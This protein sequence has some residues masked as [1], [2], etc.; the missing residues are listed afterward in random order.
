[1]TTVIISILTLTLFSLISLLAYRKTYVKLIRKSN[2]PY[3]FINE[4]TTN[5]N[6]SAILF[7][8]N[9][10]MLSPNFGSDIGVNIKSDWENSPYIYYLKRSE[11]SPY[12]IYKMRV[13]GKYKDLKNLIITYKAQGLK[14]NLMIIPNFIGNEL[15]KITS[16]GLEKGIGID[17]EKEYVVD[18]ETNY[19]INAESHL[20]FNLSPFGKVVLLLFT[21]E[22]RIAKKS[23][24]Y[25]LIYGCDNDLI[26]KIE[27]NETVCIVNRPS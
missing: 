4:N 1:M 24:L 14:G 6:K 27:N 23:L 26:T 18:I 16:I 9:Q 5:E 8:S 11:V 7:G 17:D 12:I 25:S 10:Y 20:S 2:T 13:K 15:D 22:E 3:V 21:K 19:N